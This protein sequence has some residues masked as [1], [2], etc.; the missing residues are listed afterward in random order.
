MI[1]TATIAKALIALTCSFTRAL[2]R[3]SWVC[4]FFVDTF[5]KPF[6]AG[7]ALLRPRSDRIG[8]S[9]YGRA[10]VVCELLLVRLACL[11]VRLKNLSLRGGDSESEPLNSRGT[12]LKHDENSLNREGMAIQRRG[13][14]P[15]QLAASLS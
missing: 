3:S 9:D 6:V 14:Q 15:T 12:C 13:E 10:H 5:A 7:F 2:R 11:K 4:N 8:A 1:L